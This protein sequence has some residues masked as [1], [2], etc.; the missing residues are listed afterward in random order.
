[1]NT[2]RHDPVQRRLHKTEIADL[3]RQYRQGATVYELAD[4]FGIHRTTVSDHLRRQCVRLRGHRMTGS[5]IDQAAALY[6]AGLSLARVGER[7]GFDGKTI[8]NALHAKGV[9]MR[10]SHGR[11]R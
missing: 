8:M 1:M 9:R 7:L 2:V 5:E 10:D 4:S 11:E 6:Q 3:V